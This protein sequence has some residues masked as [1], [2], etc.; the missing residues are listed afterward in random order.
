MDL[1]LW[2]HAE[3]EDNWNDMA[4]KLTSKGHQQAKLSALWLQQHLPN[5]YQVYCSEAVRAQQTANYLKQSLT[6][7]KS[8]NPDSHPL[9][10]ATFLQQQQPTATQIWVGHQPWIGQFCAYLLNGVWLPQQ[11][12]SVK[13]SAFW[14]FDIRFNQQRH[15]ARLKVALSPAALK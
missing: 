7:H 10:L 13:K 12:W 4:R 8:L 2:R 9:N 3:A 15:Q 6:I 1:I 14:W 11:F 5:N